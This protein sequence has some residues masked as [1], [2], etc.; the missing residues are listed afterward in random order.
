[1]ED[2]TEGRGTDRKTGATPVRVERTGLTTNYTN[3]END[4]KER[5]DRDRGALALKKKLCNDKRQR[6]YSDVIVD[7]VSSSTCI[8]EISL[9]QQVS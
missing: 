1:M 5:A 3:R 8:S 9:C 4:K 6:C 7:Q 2:T